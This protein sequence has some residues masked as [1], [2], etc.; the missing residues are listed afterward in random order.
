MVSDSRV[1]GSVASGC[2]VVSCPS[3]ASDT[4]AVVVIALFVVA[5]AEVAINCEYNHHMIVKLN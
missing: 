1:L 4:S 3:V 5:R 2:S